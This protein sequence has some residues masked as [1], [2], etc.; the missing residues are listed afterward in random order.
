M[1]RE[2]LAILLAL[3]LPSAW[4]GCPGD[5]DDAADDDAADDDAADD[6]TGGDDDAADDDSGDDDAA[7]DDAADDD[8]GDD[9]GGDDDSA[10]WQPPPGTSW[11]IQYTGT[12]DYTVDVAVYDLD[13]ED[14][15]AIT[16]ADLQA[17]GR[18]VLCYFSAGSYEEWRSDAWMFPPE[19]LG[20]DLDG[21]EG[22]RWLDVTHAE[23]RDIM[24]S[25]LDRAAKKGCDAVDPDNVDGYTNDPGFPFG[26]AE[27]LDYNLFLASEAHARGL[28]IGLKNDLDQIGDLLDHFD[29]AVNEECFD[30]EECDLLLP[31]VQQGK[32]VFQIQ[33]DPVG[34]AGQIC[35]DANAMQL[36]TLL[37]HL[38]LDAWRY[39]CAEDYP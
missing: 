14:T 29:F 37:K 11:Q 24:R 33:Y 38:D 25:R 2:H 19:A 1:A 9:D 35:P 30:Y 36:D 34:Q 13:L 18:R 6:D 12:M 7:D 20:N 15:S 10:P 28:S 26:Y 16:I 5:D 17:Q 3:I 23:V 31:F 8:S 21:W 32:A 27:Q 22:E 4:C 39:S